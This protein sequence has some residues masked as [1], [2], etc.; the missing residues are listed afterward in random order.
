MLIRNEIAR[1]IP[2]IPVGV[3][4]AMGRPKQASGTK[5]EI[6]DRLRAQMQ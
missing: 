4:E 1:G 6:L 5:A 3:S 2:A